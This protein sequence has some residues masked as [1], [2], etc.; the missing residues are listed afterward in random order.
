MTAGMKSKSSLTSISTNLR[1]DSLTLMK[2]EAAVLREI[3]KPLSLEELE[4]P[5][6]QRGQ[7]LVKILYSG[8]CGRQLNEIK[9]FYG[10]DKYL[11]HTLGHE[12]SG[13]V[14]KTGP[15]VSNVKKGDYVALTWIKGAGINAVPAKYTNGKG[16]I[17]NSGQISTFGKYM[18]VAENRM[19]KIP[20]EVPPNLA[21]PLGCA[22]PTGVGIIKNTLQVGKGSSIAIFGVGGIGLSAVIGAGLA[23]CAKIIAV[24][25]HESKLEIAKELGATHTINSKKEDAVAKVRELTGG[26]GADYSVEASS[27]PEVM[28][29]AYNA[30]AA[31]GKVALCGN[32]KKGQKIS[33]DPH[34]LICGKILMG[35]DLARTYKNEEIP[36][37]AKLYL[38]GKLKLEKLITH[39]YK[40]DDINKAFE[41]LEKGRIA[42]GIIEL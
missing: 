24:D 18:V 3:G 16:E 36:H 32:I 26:K 21:P 9:G 19:A 37:Y 29:M 23:G 33:V 11:P 6:L 28:E 2:T 20:K 5:E 7:V 4:I 30:T 22:I 1:Y 40:L 10:E 8:M 17:I 14:E 13:I 15:E 25:I 42:R 31:P 34:G 12:G 35:T 39:K 38:E 41:D 27:F